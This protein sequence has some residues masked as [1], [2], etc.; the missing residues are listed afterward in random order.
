MMGRRRRRAPSRL[1]S[2]R[3]RLAL[4][5]LLLGKLDSDQNCV[6]GGKADQHH[7]ADLRVDIVLHL[8]HVRRQKETQHHAAQPKHSE[9]TREYITGVLS[10]TLNGRVQ[11][12]YS[13]A[14][15]RKTK[16]RVTRIRR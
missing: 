14:R 2:I 4:F 13:A 15:I 3:G 1:R 11:L 5:V 8:D 16:R 9:S 12:S 7:E 10:N 6:L